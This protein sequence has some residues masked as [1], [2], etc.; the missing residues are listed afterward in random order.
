M[1][2]SYCEKCGLRVPD[3]D[4]KSGAAVRLPTNAVLCA[5]CA[6]A[7]RA[8][9]KT[10][11]HKAVPV[12]AETSVSGAKPRARTVSVRTEQP[13]KRNLLLAAGGVVA[14]L[15]GLVLLVATRR[16]PPP[17]SVQA[18][19]DAVVPPE[20]T[21]PAGLAVKKA[22]TPVAPGGSS[23]A[24]SPTPPGGLFSTLRPGA[25]TKESGQPDTGSPRDGV[26]ARRL[27][28]I[29]AFAKAHPDEAWEYG[30]QLTDFLESYRSTPAGKEAA[31]LLAEWKPPAGGRVGQLLAHWKF[32]ETDGTS[33]QD[34]AG[35]NHAT[36]RGRVTHVAGKV[37][38]GA[39]ALG[40]GLDDYVDLGSAP[41][42]N[43][44]AGAPFTIAGW[45]KTTAAY[46][47]LV[48]FRSPANDGAVL[49]IAVGF[50]GGADSPGSLMALVR[51]DGGNDQYARVTGGQVNTGSWRHFA[52]TRN[53]QGL[54]R[55]SL[56]GV[57]QGSHSG[58]ESAGAITTDMRACGVERLWA[59]TNFNPAEK[60][61][62][63]CEMDDLR[64]YNYALS[65]SEIRELAAG[66]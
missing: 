28:A 17:R 50:D 21:K 5:K 19:P 49:D 26:A 48:S 1:Q 14:G 41:S 39:V 59:T 40:G 3:A 63:A 16:P 60:R 53:K 61:A 43:F 57:L 23:D 4:M 15:L 52:L 36:L 35:N 46:G 34:A 24:D 22:D 29:N 47:A 31:R 62:L 65:Q 32:D 20:K 30:E 18:P 66:K 11:L 13:N 9:G 25:T 33:A 10:T 55:L 12:H 8:P 6:A 64:I 38:A 27:E 56:D 42:L 37:G 2:I 45:V 58:A 51:Q 44:A 54:I 7:K